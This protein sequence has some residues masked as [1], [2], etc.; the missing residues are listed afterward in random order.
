MSK[1]IESFADTLPCSDC[2]EHFK[3]VLE[4]NP[5]SEALKGRDEL[6]RWGVA[7]HNIVNRRLGKKEYD[8]SEIHPKY[9]DIRASI[10]VR[11]DTNCPGLH[12][13][14][15]G[16]LHTQHTQHTQPKQHKTGLIIVA[17]VVGLVAAATAFTR[18][19]PRVRFSL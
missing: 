14:L 13:G 1:Y 18:H 7:V 2:R 16:G 3:T 6:S 11:D 10:C 19:R 17:V 8:F 4:S 15:H 5:Y 9:E 12:G